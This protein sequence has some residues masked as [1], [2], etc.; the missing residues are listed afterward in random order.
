MESYTK[1]FAGKLVEQE[2][3]FVSRLHLNDPCNRRGSCLGSALIISA[4][5]QFIHRV[6]RQLLLSCTIYKD[7][8]IVSLA[9]QAGETER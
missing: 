5:L 3:I 9:Q 6:Q 2:V 7:H 8:E 4:M 1:L